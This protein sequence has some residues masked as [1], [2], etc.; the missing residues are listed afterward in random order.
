MPFFLQ[1][2]FVHNERIAAKKENRR[3]KVILEY[4]YLK[5][6]P[7]L[8]EYFGIQWLSDIPSTAMDESD[9]RQLI[10]QRSSYSDFVQRITDSPRIQAILVSCSHC[11]TVCFCT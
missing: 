9:N 7:K 10:L 1:F 11:V 5:S 2:S 6:H 8:K 4:D 3:E